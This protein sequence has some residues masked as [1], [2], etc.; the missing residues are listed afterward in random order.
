MENMTADKL[1]ASSTRGGFS[2]GELCSVTHTS[3]IPTG[4]D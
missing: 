3:T 4:Y 1:T 2:N